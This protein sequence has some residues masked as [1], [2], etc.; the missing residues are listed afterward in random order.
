MTRIWRGALLV[1]AGAL[2]VGCDDGPKQTF[3]PLPPGMTATNTSPDPPFTDMVPKQPLGASTAGSNALVLCTP[4]KQR[5]TWENALKQPIVPIRGMGGIDA[6]ANLTFLGVSIDDVEKQ[7]CQGDDGG[8]GDTF[9]GEQGELDFSWSTSTRLV[10][11]VSAFAGYRGILAFTHPRTKEK[12]TVSLESRPID[13]N[14]QPCAG[15]GATTRTG[16]PTPPA[17]TTPS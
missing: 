4:E 13:I 6:S 3:K 5:K 11:Q 15:T 12:F 17:S 1:C 10:T 14:G 7:L 8:P 2:A 9:F 16:P